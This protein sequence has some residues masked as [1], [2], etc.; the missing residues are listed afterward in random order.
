MENN[1]YSGA[2]N[3]FRG[4]APSYIA[5]ANSG[6]GMQNT[7][8]VWTMGLESAKAYPI[9]PGRTILLM[10]SESPR[11]FIKTVDMNGYA[12]LK[13]YTF[14]EEEAAVNNPAAAEY[15][16]KS[17]LEEAIAAAITQIRT[18]EEKPKQLL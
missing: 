16:T 7:N 4:Y 10:D 6:L 9:S 5:T 12:S 2:P 14:Q 1:Y 15:V 8:I 13:A 11:F 17:Q 3:M 18:T